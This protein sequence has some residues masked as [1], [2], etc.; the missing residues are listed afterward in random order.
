MQ[1][2][3]ARILIENKVIK[4]HTLVEAH[5]FAKGLSCAENSKV[6]GTFAI[7][8]AIKRDDK[9][10]L[11]GF[12]ESNTPKEIDVE[13][14]ISVDGMDEARLARAF[15]F[16]AE[17]KKITEG[18]RRGRKPKGYIPEATSADDLA[19]AYEFMRLLNFGWSEEQIAAHRL[20]TLEEV[21]RVLNTAYS[22]E[23]DED[24][25]EEDDEFSGEFADDDE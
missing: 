12:N 20:C 19:L 9:I 21:E 10:F 15:M 11:Q 2:E 3:L 16:S 6:L 17:G 5:Y 7:I 8:K 23:Y 1:A 24:E 13:D 4:E 14:V 18:K 22:D 25:G